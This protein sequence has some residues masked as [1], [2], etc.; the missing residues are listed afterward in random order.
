MKQ[1]IYTDTLLMGEI[2]REVNRALAQCKPIENIL[3]E[4]GYKVSRENVSDCITMRREQ[5]QG[6]LLS[7][8]LNAFTGAVLKYAVATKW[9]GCPHLEEELSDKINNTIDSRHSPK[10]QQEE[11]EAL[12]SEFEVMLFRCYEQIH[13]TTDLFFDYS[14][15]LRWFDVEDGKIIL[16]P[17]IEK[18]IE[19]DATIYCNSKKAESAFELHKQAAEAL[20]KFIALFPRDRQ[21]DSVGDL[22]VINCNEVV[23]RNINYNKYLA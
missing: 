2:K 15:F 18:L 14:H 22:F 21:P 8:S 6:E 7:D 1:K 9:V 10:R 11:R 12:Q 23:I 19:E 4:Y 13:P 17:Q 5:V 16:S 20:T 3:V